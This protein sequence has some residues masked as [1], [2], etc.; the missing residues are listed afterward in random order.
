M[1]QPRV[2]GIQLH[3]GRHE[4]MA[5]VEEATAEA[6]MGLVGDER[7]YGLRAPGTHITFVSADDVDAMVA[8]TGI[9]LDPLETRRNVVTR[10]A[11]LNEL[12]GRRFRV[13]EAVCLG[14][15]PCTPCNHLE[16][17][18]RPGVRIGLSGRGGLRADIVEGGTIRVGDAITILD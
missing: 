14:V 9:S 13:G 16:S 10:G 6:G 17:I 7:V 12:I 11:A 15:K 2:E 8:E 1:S 18:T 4:P 3:R 5:I